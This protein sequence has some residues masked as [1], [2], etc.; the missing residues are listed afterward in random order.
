MQKVTKAVIPAAGFGTRFLPQTKAM[1]KEMLPLVDKPVIQVVVE[2]LVDAG[3]RDI[4]I[5]TGRHKKVVED[6]FDKNAELEALL[7]ASGKHEDIEKIDKISTLA[8]FIYI[9]QKGPV[10]N[11][12]PIYNSLGLL[13]NEPFLVFWG[14][15]FV[16]AVPSRAKQLIAVYEKYGGPV[17]GAIRTSRRQDGA[18]YGFATGKRLP[19]GVLEVKEVV[20]KPG[21]GKAPSNLATV[22][23]FLLTPEVAPFIE[24]IVEGGKGKEPNYIDALT[25]FLK[26]GGKVYA[27]ELENA[28]Y[29]DT[30]SKLGY[31]E[32]VV[33]FGLK[34]KETKT[35][36]R[37]YLKKLSL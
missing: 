6:H 17:L 15:D 27:K 36:F 20:E 12:T 25:L 14:D 10:G 31:L 2:E 8:N 19:H 13:N 33:E 11:G 9:R 4:I 34:N 26:A 3:I 37:K 22:S 16:E 7:K 21:V 23:G 30:G 29:F 1:P 5:V 24:K 32:A 28:R 35:G 18:K